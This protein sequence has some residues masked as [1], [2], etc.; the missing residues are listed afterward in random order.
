MLLFNFKVDNTI[1]SIYNIKGVFVLF[2]NQEKISQF[3][4]MNSVLTF[5]GM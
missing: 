3:Q 1:Y 5:F 2:K 4:N